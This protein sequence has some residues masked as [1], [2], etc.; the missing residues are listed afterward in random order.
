VPVGTV[1]WREA[2]EGDEKWEWMGELTAEGRRMVVARGG[3]GGRGNHR[4]VSSTNQEPLL[5]EGGEEGESRRLLLE[6]KWVADVGVVGAPNAGKSTLLAHISRARPKIADYPFTTLDPVLGVA[7]WKRRRLVVL[8]VPG[9][10]EGAHEGRGLGLEFLRHAE[11]VSVLVHMVDG[12]SDDAAAEY[13]Q[14]RREL[15]AHSEELGGKPVVVVVNKVDIPEVREARARIVADV[16]KA[17]G[18]K[19]LVLSAATGEGMDD[20]LDRLLEM[21]PMGAPTTEE[22]QKEA[23]APTAADPRRVDI[24]R[25]DDVYVVRCLQAERYLP[26]I[27]LGNWRTRMQ[28]HH[29]LERLGVIEALRQAGAET[30]DS[31][32]I[33]SY[34]LE[35]Q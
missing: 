26:V 28:F 30:G 35:W 2:G 13:E 34:E 3:R 7:E 12:S 23:P 29:E 8:D 18:A 24:G 27:N 5:A 14:V 21:V 17:A 25:E 19:P 10:I 16:A 6:V 33:G 15:E 4:F 11:R 32:R 31:V 9:L 20:L 1:I 22:A